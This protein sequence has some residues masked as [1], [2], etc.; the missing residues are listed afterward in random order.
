LSE[1]AQA[2]VDGA[3]FSSANVAYV[4]SALNL[5]ASSPQGAKDV[6]AAMPSLK[7]LSFSGYAT[8]APYFRGL[9]SAASATAC[10]GALSD[11]IK[12]GSATPGADALKEVRKLID[13]LIDVN[14]PTGLADVLTYTVNGEANSGAAEVNDLLSVLDQSASGEADKATFLQKLNQYQSS[15]IAKSFQAFGVALAATNTFAYALDGDLWSSLKNGGYAARDLTELA[16]TTTQIFTGVAKDAAEKFIP[17][18]GA[19]ANIISGYQHVS[20]FFK[21]GSPWSVVA[22]TGD[23]IAVVGNLA[24]IPFP[25]VG[26]AI[27]GL[28]LAISGFGDFLSLGDKER[29]TLKGN[30]ET[31]LGSLRPAWGEY[32]CNYLENSDP[33]TLKRLADTGVSAGTFDIIAKNHP[34]FAELSDSD[35]DGLK[36]MIGVVGNADQ[37]LLDLPVEVDYSW[38]RTMSPDQ[39]KDLIKGLKDVHGGSQNAWLAS[40]AEKMRSEQDPIKRAG[41]RQIYDNVSA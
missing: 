20:D 16:T 10:R 22:A 29:V 30:L 27:N 12:S 1:N 11:A 5:L 28:G 4:K 37:A 23:L 32:F 38:N 18:V 15:P 7:T 8:T 41:Y 33:K 2:L 19:G 26:S 21:Q 6:L 25:G 35:L 3:Q 14:N 40:L 36:E 39:Q 13:P 24:A 17:F 31:T 9:F 34:S